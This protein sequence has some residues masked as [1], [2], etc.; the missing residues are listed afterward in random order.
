[1]LK[2]IIFA[3]IFIFAKTIVVES[4][5]DGSRFHDIDSFDNMPILERDNFGNDN[6]NP[7]PRRGIEFRKYLAPSVKI[8][9]NGASGSGTIIHYDVLTKLAY[10]A[11]CGHLWQ[12]GIM[13][14]DEGKKR[15]MKCKV[16][17]W[18]HNDQKLD[19]PRSYEAN[20]IFY[21]Y[22]N[23]Q[24]TGLITFSPDWEPN[25]FPIGPSKYIYN[26]NQHA[27]SVGCDAG[28]EVVHYDVKMIGIEGD[29]LVT[30]ENSPRPG[31][32][33]GGLMNDDGQYIGTC[34]GTQYRDGTGKGYFTPLSVIHKFWKKQNGY[35]FLLDQ[36]TAS[37]S[38]KQIKIN[39]R[40][41][42]KEEFKPEYILLP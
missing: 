23:G 34:W 32:S 6:P 12:Q 18:Y 8:G 14:V 40:S 10:V 38:A 7:I 39:D 36:K 13:N 19:S 15:N 3:I 41:G 24:D 5:Q 33:G 22:V 31:R 2:K 4:H 16:I 35:A 25:Y 9:V 37:N 30:N 20:V 29:D 28:T 26:E 1:M 17:V 11:T 42:R 27:H 21:S